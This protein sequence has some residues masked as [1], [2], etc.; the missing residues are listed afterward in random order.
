MRVLPMFA[1]LFLAACGAFLVF[2]LY[3]FASLSDPGAPGGESGPSA[4][5][6]ATGDGM[7]PVGLLL[8]VAGAW[9]AFSKP[10]RAA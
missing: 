7:F 10:K 5:S 4:W 1:G 3:G 9:L 6:K 2:M 8:I